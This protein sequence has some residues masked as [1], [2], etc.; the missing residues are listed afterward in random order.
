RARDAAARDAHDDRVLELDRLGQYAPGLRAVAK[1]RRDP[2]DESHAP[3][4]ASRTGF[5]RL[6]CDRRPEEREVRVDREGS[7]ESGPCR[8]GGEAAFDHRPV[9]DEEGVP[10]AEPERSRRVCAGLCAAPGPEEAPGER[11]LG[12]DAGRGRVRAASTRERVGD[13]PAVVEIEDGGL[14]LG[15]D[16]VRL[17]QSLDRPDE[18][19]LAL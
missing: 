4:V 11:V 7:T 13:V 5:E 9:E 3:I 17:E 14:E 2:G 18:R 8:W 12:V 15:A 1:E 19:V 6:P 16:A 10:G